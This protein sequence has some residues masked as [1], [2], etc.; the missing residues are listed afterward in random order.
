MSEQGILRIDPAAGEDLDLFAEALL[1]RADQLC[2]LHGLGLLAAGQQ[3]VSAALDQ[4]LHRGKRIFTDIKGA[5]EYRL[6]AKGVDQ[7]AH[8][9]RVL[10]GHAAVFIQKAEGDA[11]CAFLKQYA[12]IHPS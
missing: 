4:R 6:F 11:V 3:S 10:C 2:P 8:G 12:R 1:Q 5:V 9:S 7:S